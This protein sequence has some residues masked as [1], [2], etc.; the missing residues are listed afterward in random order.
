MKNYWAETSAEYR[1]LSDSMPV[2][3][4]GYASMAA[5][6]KML[7]ASREHYAREAERCRKDAA[8]YGMRADL[9]GAR[10][11]EF[12]DEHEAVA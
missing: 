11:E 4:A 12:E 2:N 10:A 5:D 7:P 9:H 8:Y 6:P 3:A 1:R